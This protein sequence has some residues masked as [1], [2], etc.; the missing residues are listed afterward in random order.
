MGVSRIEQLRELILK[1]DKD[2][3]ESLGERIESIDRRAADIAEVLPESIS[4]SYAHDPRLIGALRRPLKQCISESVRDEPDEYAAALFPVMGPAIRRSITETLRTWTAQ[5]SQVI[6]QSLSPRGIRWRF[7]AWRAGVPFGQYVIQQTLIYRVEDVYLIH[8]KSGLLIRHVTQ[9]QAQDMDEDAVSAMFTAIQ[10]FVNDSF[11]RGN[12]ERL[13][14]AELDDLTLWAVHG[15]STTIVAVIRGVAP[16]ELRSRLETAIEGIERTNNRALENYAGDRESVHDVEPKLEAC[17]LAATRTD[18]QESRRPTAAIAVAAAVVLL[19]VAWMAYGFWM[20]AKA[21]A[22]ADALGTTPGIILTG[23]ERDGSSLSA[24]GLRDRLARDPSEIAAEAGW[25]GEFR[26]RFRPFLS[27]DEQIVADRARTILAPPATVSLA[28]TDG[29]L[30]LAGSAAPAWIEQVN[31][32]WTRITGIDRI[33]ATQLAVDSDVPLPQSVES[34]DTAAVINA[35]DREL[36]EL[37]QAVDASTFRFDQGGAEL[38]AA[39]LAEIDRVVPALLSYGEISTRL[40]RT[41]RLIITGH[42]DASGSESFNRALEINRAQSVET[43]LV[44][45]GI[46]DQWL[47]ARGQLS[48]QSAGAREPSVTLMLESAPTA[49]NPTRD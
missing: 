4:E 25:T 44:D 49:G 10:S 36:T 28:I 46:P 5:F 48:S 33:D 42:S 20:N 43:A 27:L 7:Q 23:I 38:S 2:R 34:I 9:N 47:I 8:S 35:E 16:I 14:T 11:A 31:S 18:S 15:P 39:S 37:S 17:L 1:P 12:S 40:G 30:A 3:L 21:A 19:I 32:N 22:V 45:A 41:P 6:E 24:S 29:T 26:A 13:T